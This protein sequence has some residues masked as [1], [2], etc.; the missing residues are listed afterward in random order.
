MYKVKIG[1]KAVKFLAKLNHKIQRQIINKLRTLAL[2]PRPEGYTAIKGVKNL[3]RIR[4]G[5]YRIVYSIYDKELVVLVIR[6]GHRKDIY[7]RLMN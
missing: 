5:N 3:F 4:S 7:D 1:D 2:D 6:I